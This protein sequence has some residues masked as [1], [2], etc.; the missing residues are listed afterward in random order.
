MLVS[1]SGLTKKVVLVVHYY[2]LQGNS[3]AERSSHR[4]GQMYFIFHQQKYNESNT[5]KHPLLRLRLRLTPIRRSRQNWS[6]HFCQ[7]W[8]QNL[9]CSVCIL[10]CRKKQD[11]YW[12]LQKKSDAKPQLLQNGLIMLISCV[13]NPGRAV[14]PEQLRQ[15]DQARLRGPAYQCKFASYKL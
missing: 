5:I 14:L 6:R 7:K 13:S 11:P 15:E 2:L 10:P 1:V 3:Y 12:S 4:Q 9:H 8:I